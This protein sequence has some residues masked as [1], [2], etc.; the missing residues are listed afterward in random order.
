MKPDGIQ[1]G[2]MYEL[3]YRVDPSYYGGKVP[4]RFGNVGS[5]SGR[6]LGREKEDALGRICYGAPA[7]LKMTVGGTLGTGVVGL[8]A[9]V[10]D[11]DGEENRR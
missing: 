3:H 7:P 6:K 2:D 11:H 1:M 8:G 9:W 4:Q 10:D 5:W